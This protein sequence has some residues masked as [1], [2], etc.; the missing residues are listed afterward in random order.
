MNEHKLNIIERLRVKRGASDLFALHSIRS[1]EL[2]MSDGIDYRPAPRL[3]KQ[4][5]ALFMGLVLLLGVVMY[6]YYWL[7]LSFISSLWNTF[8]WLMLI[9]LPQIWFGC[10]AVRSYRLSNGAL[11]VKRVG[12]AKQIELRGLQSAVFTPI[13]CWNLKGM[14]GVMRFAKWIDN[15]T[16]GTY[17][18]FLT[19]PSKAV[20]LKFADHTVVVTPDQPEQFAHDVLEYCSISG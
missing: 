3:L 18:L 14:A 16:V 9:S 10:Q 15:N 12:R 19:N 2:T 11:I 4:K 1:M 20:V 13:E 7:R 6:H 17:Q 5:I 8:F